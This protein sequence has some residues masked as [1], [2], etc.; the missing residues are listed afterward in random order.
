[1]PR[2]KKEVLPPE[3]CASVRDYERS[4]FW[5]KKSQAILDDK[6]LVCSICGR[7]RWTWMP[8]A[9]KWK[10]RRFSVHHKHYRTVGQEEPNDLVPLCNLCH[11]MC[12]D[13]LRYKN[14]SIMYTELAKIVEQY[15]FYEGTQSFHPW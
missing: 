12:H 11:T 6:E 13:I 3:H 5:K 8:R 1:M 15:F 4:P 14:I 9:K 2:K 10:K 7:P